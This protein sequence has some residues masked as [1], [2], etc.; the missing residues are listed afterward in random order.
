MRETINGL[1]KA[2]AIHKEEP[3]KGLDAVEHATPTW[4]GRFNNR[5]IRE[6]IGGMPPAEYEML[7]DQQ[8]EPCEAAWPR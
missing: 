5:R 8:T 1:F 7:Y 3:W 6:A 2:E 4:V